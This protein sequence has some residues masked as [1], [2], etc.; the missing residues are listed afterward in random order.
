MYKRVSS[1]VILF[2]M[3]FILLY[4][5]PRVLALQNENAA[6]ALL[7]YDS[8]AI[9]TENEGNVE[10]LQ[11]LL[12]SFGVKLTVQ[13]EGDYQSGSMFQYEKVISLVNE[14]ELPEASRTFAN[15]L[16]AYP[17]DF[18][19]IGGNVP[20]KVKDELSLKL[21]ISGQESIRLS[22]GPF[23][24][25]AIQVKQ[26]AYIAEA[27]GKPYGKVVSDGN[28]EPSPYGMIRDGIAY[29]SFFEKGNLSE[30]AMSYMLKDWLGMTE[31]S[32]HYVVFKEIYPF[33][34]LE[35]LVKLA[36]KLYGAGIP[37]MASVRPVLSN[38]DY[39]AMKRYLEALK[40]VQSK[41]GTILI[42]APAVASTISELDRDLRS[43]MESFIDVLADYG[44][45]P[46]GM[47]AELY[48]SYDS[49]YVEKA[50][51]LFDSALLFPNEKLMHKSR[52]NT[53]QPFASSVYSLQPD[54]L[55]AYEYK[56]KL[57]KPLPMDTALT[58][59][60][61]Q[62]EAVL[63]EEVQKLIDGWT[64]FAD[65]KAGEHSVKTAKNSIVSR[66]GI[67][68]I[69]GQ[70]LS[71]VSERTSIDSDYIYEPEQAVSFEKWF[72]VQNKLFIGIILI[73]IAVFAVLFFLGSRMYRRKYFK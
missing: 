65:F 30:I 13:S 25:Q 24:E 51:S 44:I 32:E 6:A 39:P 55:E 72:A 60:F 52:T 1:K 14:P 71:L 8:L 49:Y 31:P 19:Y 37:F 41:N 15:D 59:D 27:E 57:M 16:E 66:N 67:L 35:L 62:N 17:G 12:A 29:I 45:A 34:D 70:S 47:G 61:A 50:M 4:P 21:Q 22:I 26:I 40:Y 69:N 56:E 18:L 5:L 58:F 38:T 33:S 46:L 2:M 20:A 64:M 11:R 54:D 9:G 42:H 63:N 10:A 36:D 53:S 68:Q 23:M 3:G 28:E 43:Q 48:W 7:V 73:A